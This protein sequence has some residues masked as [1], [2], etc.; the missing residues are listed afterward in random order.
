MGTRHDAPHP[1]AFHVLQYSIIVGGHDYFGNGTA[2]LNLFNDALNH[3]FSAN[4]D[5]WLSRK[6]SACVTGGY[7]GNNS[8]DAILQG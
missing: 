5:E 1:K 3:A 7:D 4:V 8:H 2:R 6:P